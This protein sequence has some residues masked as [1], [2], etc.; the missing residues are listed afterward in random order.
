MGDTGFSPSFQRLHVA[1]EVDDLVVGEGVE[2]AF[3]HDGLAVHV[4]GDL[5]ALDGNDLPGAAGE[6]LGGGVRG[7]VAVAAVPEISLTP[8]WAS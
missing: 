3:R 7:F 5:D 6:T 8:K 2:Q 4:A 1:D